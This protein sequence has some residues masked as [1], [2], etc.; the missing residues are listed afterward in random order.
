MPLLKILTQASRGRRLNF[1]CVMS[2]PVIVYAAYVLMD[3]FMPLFMLGFIVW[4]LYNWTGKG[5][6]G[7]KPITFI[8]M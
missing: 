1:I 8:G 4:L 6:F 7:D 5:V 3:R 2:F